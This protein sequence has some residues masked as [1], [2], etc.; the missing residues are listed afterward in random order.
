MVTTP[1]QRAFETKRLAYSEREA[2]VGQMVRVLPMFPQWSIKQ[3]TSDKSF[4]CVRVL[5][6]RALIMRTLLAHRWVQKVRIHL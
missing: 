5:R 3:S 1:K 6:S 4:P 2:L